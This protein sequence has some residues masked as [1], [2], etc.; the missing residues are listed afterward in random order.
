VKFIEPG[1]E[2]VAARSWKREN[3]KLSIRYKVSVLQSKSSGDR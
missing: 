2:K 3:R 1:S